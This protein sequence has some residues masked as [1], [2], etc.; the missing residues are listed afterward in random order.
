MSRVLVRVA[1]YI[2]FDEATR[3]SLLKWRSSS[4]I[5]REAQGTAKGLFHQPQA[6]R[7]PQDRQ[8]IS[9]S[10]VAKSVG[11][12]DPATATRE[13]LAELMVG[14]PG[15]LHSGEGEA[16]P[17]QSSCR[18]SNWRCSMTVPPSPS[19]ACRSR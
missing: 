6:E 3:C 13:H 14:R 19:T 1:R 10:G 12:A 4:R 18:S 9:S 15:S 11:E 8:R 5:V 2:I 7:G 16:N 17:G